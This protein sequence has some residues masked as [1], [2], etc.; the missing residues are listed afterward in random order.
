MHYAIIE[1]GLGQIGIGWTERGVARL[2]LPS[3]RLADQLSRWGRRA[4]PP[5]P[6]L[7]LV[8]RV[9]R[10]GAGDPVDFGGFELDLGSVP[11][12]HRAAYMDIRRLKWGQTTTYGDIARRLGD[13]QL[14]RA[15]GQAMGANP[16]PLIIPCH[17]VLGAD[18]K[19]GGFSSPGGVATKMKMLAIEQA[20]T[21]QGQFSF[22]F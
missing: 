7:P 16:I 18:G 3:N 13:V 8:E 11:D 12:F 17:R 15:V 4:D 20:A 22:G 2:A 19:T 21:P 14:A 9:T 10:Y 1:T 5:E 6:I